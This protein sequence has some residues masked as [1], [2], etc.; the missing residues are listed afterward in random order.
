MMSV[1]QSAGPALPSL[2]P[3]QGWECP[4]VHPEGAGWRWQTVGRDG[5]GRGKYQDRT[6]TVFSRVRPTSGR[7]YLM[8]NSPKS[9]NLLGGFAWAGSS[10]SRVSSP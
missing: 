5:G 10:C 4:L 1:V 3:S 8:S 7:V 6:A 9:S 2:Q